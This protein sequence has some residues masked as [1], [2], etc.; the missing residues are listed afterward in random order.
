MDFDFQI[1]QLSR[2]FYEDH[3]QEKYPEL[4]EKDKR[5]YTC[6]VLQIKDGYFICIPF[7]TE[8]KHNNGFHFKHSKRASDH[9]SG[10][11]YSKI[12]IISDPEYLSDEPAIVDKDEY[13]EVV[14]NI[15]RI[16]EEVNKYIDDYVHT[17]KTGK[18]DNRSFARRYGYTTLRYFEKELNS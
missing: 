4:L 18:T 8:M 3:P 6:L 10:L 11:D 9:S 7:R 17:V 5:A 14:C 12:V 15:E 13:N 1:L 2:R 16:V